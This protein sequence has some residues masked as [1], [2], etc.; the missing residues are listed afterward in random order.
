[1]K[2]HAQAMCEANARGGKH[3]LFGGCVE[4]VQLCGG[5]NA[6]KRQTAEVR[7]LVKSAEK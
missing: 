4:P 5:E 2:G 7:N 1:M 3:K 6:T